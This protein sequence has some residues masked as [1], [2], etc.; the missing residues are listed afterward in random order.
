MSGSLHREIKNSVSRPGKRKKKTQRCEG[1]W[2]DVGWCS[3]GRNGVQQELES[4]T[5]GLAGLVRVKVK[6]TFL[7]KEQHQIPKSQGW[8]VPGCSGDEDIAE[9]HQH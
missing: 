6:V 3:N 7:G 9:S 2:M 1:R 5:W 4:G 8:S